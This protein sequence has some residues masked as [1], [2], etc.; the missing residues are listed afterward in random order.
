MELGVKF[1]FHQEV[2]TFDKTKNAQL[3]G[4]Q[5]GSSLDGDNRSADIQC[6]NLIV[7][8]GPWTTEVLR[9]LLPWTDQPENNSQYYDWIRIP[10]INI[11]SYDN[12]GLL[13]R[14]TADGEG[15]IAAAQSRSRE[16]LVAAI[17]RKRKA[18]GVIRTSARS[19]N[20]IDENESSRA[21]MLATAVVER[22]HDDNFTEG[23]AL[24]STANNNLPI[25]G[26]IPSKVVDA[27]FEG[28]DNNPLG[29]YVAYG[30]GKHGTTLAPGTATLM[31]RMICRDEPVGE[32][33]KAFAYPGPAK[34]S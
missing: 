8:A 14:N 5:I 29:I 19:Q 18:A 26:K 11:R 31:R 28:V 1:R 9:Q 24:I 33:S 7:A 13:L 12:T 15:A 16:I 3:L 10:R 32:W 25:I 6:N 2:M 23:R 21:K 4:A 17:S 22:F 20:I 30:F 27:R 34:G